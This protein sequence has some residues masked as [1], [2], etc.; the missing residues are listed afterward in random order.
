MTPDERDAGL[1]AYALGDPGLT[2]VERAEIEQRMA[3]DPAVRRAVEEV[4]EVAKLLTAG[5]AR[6]L[7]A[8]NPP[9]VTVPAEPAAKPKQWRLRAK[10]IAIAAGVLLPLLGVMAVLP[11]FQKLREAK[12]MSGPPRMTAQ[13]DSPSY[14]VLTTESEAKPHPYPDA[15]DGLRYQAAP[16]PGAVAPVE[17]RAKDQTGDM[18]ALQDRERFWNEHPAQQPR[19]PEPPAL[20]AD[21]K[22]A[23]GPDVAK[24]EGKEDHFAFE[25]PKSPPIVR[26]TTPYSP[27]RDFKLKGQPQAGGTPLAT[28]PQLGQGFGRGVGG[29]GGGFPTARGGLPGQL[30]GEVH[31]PVPGGQPL[32][33]LKS[34]PAPDGRYG[35][36]PQPPRAGGDRFP[37]TV[38]NAFTP[39]EGQNA[40][41]T[42]GVDVDTASYS[43]IRNYI[44]RGMLPPPDAVR[45]EEVVNYFP[46]QDKPP[47]GDDPFAVT[48]EVADCPWQ[49]GHRLARIGLKA[50]PI[51]AD[52]RPPSNLVFLID[53][54]GSMNQPNKLPLVKASLKLLVGQLGE[55]DRVAMVVYAGSS[56][57]VLDST[58]ASNK[59]I[60]LEALDRLE[61]GGSTNG[62]GGLQQAYD[63]AVANFIKG[64][65]N[66]VVLCTDG[67]WNVGTTNTDALV[68]MI[69]DKRKTGVFLSVFGFGMGNLRDEMMVKLAGKGNG[70]YGYID[71]LREAHKALV[72]QLG[73][74]LVAVAKDVK[75]QV[76]F[77]PAAVKAYR[78][79]GYEK[80]ALAAKDFADDTKDAGEMGAGHVVTALYELVPVGDVAPVA[81][82]GLRYQPN[83]DPKPAAVGVAP[84][85]EAFLVKMRYKKPD[86][87]VSVL[88]ELPVANAAVPA[89]EA[90]EDFRFSA[91]AAAFALV[92]RESA[93]K[94]TATLG[95]VL[96]LAEGGDA[97][98]PERLPGR[99]R[100][101]GP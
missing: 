33:Q 77:N 85:K 89:G 50:K 94:G 86:G 44:S 46:Y 63:V 17:V 13:A 1:T 47:T 74:T 62:A 98:R 19:R 49:A 80:R 14:E 65:T 45:L 35:Y 5:F 54:S 18:K 34:E 36:I 90:S 12:S 6:E 91:A 68:R 71:T 60:I 64:G 56:G 84:A 78:L 31:N 55:N 76:E 15:K 22:P 53:V 82:E 9:G 16:P 41:S 72:E 29:F 58:S 23:P 92:L 52:Q 7:A 27:T 32:P 95:T 97:V 10:H 25:L 30:G 4:R 28:D 66:R 57:L 79:L 51:A 99:V 75:I 69:E 48:V 88:R 39:V 81:S 37:P 21:P 24:S 73:G 67:D 101:V 38:E 2:P 87:D 40:L 26:G 100:G 11:A 93:Y 43:I 83:P 42:F 3:S 70:N 61:A 59:Q 20:P 96:E 8:A